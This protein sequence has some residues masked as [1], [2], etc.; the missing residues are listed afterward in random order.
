MQAEIIAFFRGAFLRH[1]PQRYAVMQPQNADRK[2]DDHAGTITDR[3]LAAHLDGRTAYAVPTAQDGL[4]SF[5]PLDIDAG[6][7]RAARALLDAAHARGL[8]AFAQVDP[9]RGRG[10]VW[11]PF[12]DLTSAERIH[13]LGAELI[14]QVQRPGDRIENRATAE[15]TRLP[16]ARHA[17]TARRGQLVT[18][19]GAS[20]DLDGADF[21]DV[22]AAFATLYRE[23]PTSQLPPPPERV[24]EAPRRRQDAPNGSGVTIDA[25]NAA[26]DLVSLL[27]RYGAT[28]ARGQGAR[29]YFCPFHSDAHA[30][31]LVS[32]DGAHCKCLSAGSDCPLSAHQNDAFNVFCIA[33]RLTP[34]QALRRLN[35]HPDTPR[36]RPAPRKPPQEQRSAPSGI[37]PT[38]RI[39]SDAVRP[40][41]E[42]AAEPETTGEH[43][44]K[45]ARRIL[46]VIREAHGHYWRG[47]PH[48]A[49]L[50]D[51]DPRTVQRSLRRLERARLIERQERG[52]DGHTDV[53]R[54][55]QGG[56]QLPPTV[57]IKI[58]VHEELEEAGRGGIV[59]AA[60]VE[61]A[62]PA[63]LPRRTPEHPPIIDTDGLQHGPGGAVAYVGGAAY[64]PPQAEQWYSALQQAETP[65]AT[66][67][68][69]EAVQVEIP[70]QE[71]PTA[72]APKRR[73][74][75]TPSAPALDLARLPGRIIA[76]E[77]KAAKLERGNAR[78]K[79]QA[80]AIRR[81]AEAMQ[82]QLERSRASA[83]E[84]PRPE[85]DQAERQ[86]DAPPR[87]TPTTAPPSSLPGVDWVYLE[88]LARIGDVR[89]IETHC[90][91]C[92]ADV[93]AVFAELASR[94][95][96]VANGS[97]SVPPSP[98][99]AMC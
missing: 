95:Y 72:P 82:R 66:P 52:R 30:S 18:Q 1:G 17:W 93:R 76:A 78:E 36:T 20:A 35:S 42:A 9:A 10:Y 44:P 61:E 43:L 11:M 3:Q 62:P 4:A 33:E 65:P 15:D 54:I 83:A 77:R 97:P 60:T 81:S 14:A 13:A 19:D 49:R 41:Q 22:L 85:G 48:L 7:E 37:I 6:G 84:G 99:F 56:R 57:D 31:L 69:P 80:R 63:G 34:A 59:A 28:P 86:A 38:P 25:Y 94:G 24:P 50:L 75:R 87:P 47:V 89:P 68:E 73:R 27:D 64:I 2:Y 21:A 23:N 74:N 39:A 16:F 40:S 5:L 79:A 51:C 70:T 12:D 98:V 53:Y 45:T 8:W 96:F 46:D 88:R 91:L 55:R 90:T 58:T 26:T 71:P 29:L 32:R 92:R 67:Q